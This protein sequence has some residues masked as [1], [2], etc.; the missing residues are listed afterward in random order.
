MTVVIF[1]YPLLLTSFPYSPQGHGNGNDDRI[2]P[3]H[4]HHSGKVSNL[5]KHLLH[6]LLRWNGKGGGRLSGRRAGWVSCPGRALHGCRM[7]KQWG[8]KSKGKGGLVP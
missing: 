2:L 8:G 4:L 1:L 5:C 3:L 7:L 6:S